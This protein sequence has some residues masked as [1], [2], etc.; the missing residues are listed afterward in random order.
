MEKLTAST[1]SWSAR[2]T[3][4]HPS[5]MASCLL[6]TYVCPVYL[7]EKRYLGVMSREGEKGI[8]T[9]VSWEGGRVVCWKGEKGGKGGRIVRRQGWRGWRPVTWR[10]GKVG[11]RGGCSAELARWEWS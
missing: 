9:V 6:V 4:R 3:F 11:G 10:V 1:K 5:Y 8:G 7:V 2:G